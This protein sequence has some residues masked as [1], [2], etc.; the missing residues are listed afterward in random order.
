MKGVGRNIFVNVTMII[1]GPYYV[2]GCTW[3]TVATL[4]TSELNI[5]NIV[6]D[7]SSKLHRT[8]DLHV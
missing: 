4:S 1:I 6:D 2:I 7:T 8:A 5:N 3:M